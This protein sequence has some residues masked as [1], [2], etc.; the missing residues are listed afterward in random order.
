MK[1][2]VQFIGQPH[3]VGQPEN[4]QYIRLK[5]LL[6]S[7]KKLDSEDHKIYNALLEGSKYFQ[8]YSFFMFAKFLIDSLILLCT[9]CSSFRKT[10]YFN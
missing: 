1:R 7:G 5:G 4:E 9:R 10:E 3:F 6:K 2:G 8:S